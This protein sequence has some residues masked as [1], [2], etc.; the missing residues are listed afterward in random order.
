VVAAYVAQGAAAGRPRTVQRQAF[1][2]NALVI[3]LQFER[4]D[5]GSYGGSAWAEL[6]GGAVSSFAKG[7]GILDVDDPVLDVR[8]TKVGVRMGQDQSAGA[9]LR[10]G[11]ADVVIAQGAAESQLAGGV[12]AHNH[13]GAKGDVAGHRIVA[14]H[15]FN[16]AAA[17]DA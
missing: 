3:K 1:A 10:Q 6:N 11:V 16:R 9:D 5:F 14:L 17:I 15:V 2:D 7:I 13:V 4:A 12:G 8:R